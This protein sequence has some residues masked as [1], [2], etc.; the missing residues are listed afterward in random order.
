MTEEQ[1]TRIEHNISDI[2]KRID[3]ISASLA[4]LLG[5][6]ALRQIQVTRLDN[7][8]NGNGTKGLKSRVEAV[9]TK[10]IVYG[11]ILVVTSSVLSAALATI[12]QWVI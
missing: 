6:C 8:M 1:I 12:V 3:D 4:T 2:H 9:E 5:T 10:L 7:D 11:S